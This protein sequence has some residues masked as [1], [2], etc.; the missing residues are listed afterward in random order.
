VV[1][2]TLTFLNYIKTKHGYVH[3]NKFVS[4]GFFKK[5]LN[6]SACLVGV[7]QTLHSLKGNIIRRKCCLHGK[8]FTRMVLYHRKLFF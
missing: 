5:R 4:I 3:I 8:K 7:K 2:S 1:K 6:A